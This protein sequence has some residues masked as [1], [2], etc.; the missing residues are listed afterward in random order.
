MVCR[1]RKQSR[2][3]QNFKIPCIQALGTFNSG[4]GKISDNDFFIAAN[5]DRQDIMLRIPAIT[6]S[7]KWYRIADTSIEDETSLLSVENAET[8]ISQDRYVLP[9][10]SMLILVAK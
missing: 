5:T 10:S 8:L 1:R 3:E 9:A 6:D 7:R 2:L 4:A